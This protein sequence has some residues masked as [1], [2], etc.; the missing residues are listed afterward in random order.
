M[1]D[2]SRAVYEERARIRARRAER[3]AREARERLILDIEAGHHSQ[4]RFDG[5]TLDAANRARLAAI[6]SHRAAA[7]RYS[8]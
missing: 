2:Y 5:S 3:I 8:A 1:K 6:E 4:A 7:G